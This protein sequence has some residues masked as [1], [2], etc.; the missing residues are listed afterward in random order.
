M[1]FEGALAPDGPEVLTLAYFLSNI[2]DSKDRLQECKNRVDH[3]ALFPGGLCKR[4]EN[5]K[6]W[7]VHAVGLHIRY[8]CK[9]NIYEDKSLENC[10]CFSPQDLRVTSLYLSRNCL[11][12]A[13]G[14]ER[15]V[16]LESLS[17]SDNLLSVVPPELKYLKRLR[18]LH[19]LGNP[20]C[21]VPSLCPHYR[22]QVL[23]M[24]PALEILDGKRVTP[25]EVKRAQRVFSEE[26]LLRNIVF[27]LGQLQKAMDT[28]IPLSLLKMHEDILETLG[29][30][31]ESDMTLEDYMCI[32]KSSMD[33][34]FLFDK[35]FMNVWSEIDFTRNSSVNAALAQLAAIKWTDILSRLSL[36]HDGRIEDSFE[37][38]AENM[39]ASIRSVEIAVGH[40]LEGSCDDLEGIV[41]MIFSHVYILIASLEMDFIPKDEKAAEFPEQAGGLDCLSD[42]ATNVA[43]EERAL[44][45]QE[46]NAMKACVQA[47]HDQIDE[48]DG[49]IRNLKRD[50]K[51]M[52]VVLSFVQEK[53]E[54]SKQKESQLI[55]KSD[56]DRAKLESVIKQRDEYEKKL[57]E[58][59][60]KYRTY[61]E[62]AE[63][64]L[65][66][67]EKMYSS[68]NKALQRN[69]ADMRKQPRIPLNINIV[70]PDVSNALRCKEDTLLELRATVGCLTR[71]M[72]LLELAHKFNAH[73]HHI[74]AQTAL[75]EILTGWNEYSKYRTRLK[76]LEHSISEVISRRN[77][78][79]ILS[80]LGDAVWRCKRLESLSIRWQRESQ[81]S[82]KRLFFEFWRHVNRLSS[83][84][85]GCRVAK[86]KKER[87][88]VLKILREY[89]RLNRAERNN[90]FFKCRRVCELALLRKY[91]DS[92]LHTYRADNFDRKWKEFEAGKVSQNHTLKRFFSAWHAVQIREEQS[93]QDDRFSQLGDEL[94][95]QRLRN[96]AFD[97]LLKHKVLYLKLRHSRS[98]VQTMVRQGLLRRTLSAW[99]DE[100]KS[101][102][103]ALVR[104]LF[105][106]WRTNTKILSKIREYNATLLERQNTAMRMVLGYWRTFA[107]EEARK[108]KQT[109]ELLAAEQT[110]KLMM[111]KLFIRWY[112]KTMDSQLSKHKGAIAERNL[113]V[114]LATSSCNALQTV[115]MERE[116]ENMDTLQRYYSDF[117]G[118]ERSI[119]DRCCCLDAKYR[120]AVCR[121]HDEQHIQQQLSESNNVLER[122]VSNLEEQVASLQRKNKQLQMQRDVAE[123]LQKSALTRASRAEND[124]C[125]ASNVLMERLIKETNII[126]MN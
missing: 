13:R 56:F 101:Q 89:A 78:Q 50:K 25:K 44:L 87:S 49:E 85:E 88:K 125:T 9:C 75:K 94:S 12:C 37:L 58:V 4:S 103:I 96:K 47:L 79:A 54:L 82:L 16:H 3:Q 63:A 59:Q 95:K 86:A 29:I 105:N 35:D 39:S 80:M 98:A 93:R 7:K 109:A 77:K 100:N 41:A 113:H 92:W 48:K 66:E 126:H 68:A 90:L 11:N 124:L 51:G 122:K 123:T 30:D 115:L 14:L 70:S 8:F 24:C 62:V 107:F 120:D 116:K 114:Q 45:E 83:R 110:K 111:S 72:D 67:Q 81:D 10:S 121:L 55:N 117:K 74:R 76:N 18:R 119:R 38:F 99:R 36:A 17:L 2:Y 31:K 28:G 20:M 97:A 71:E 118:I 34:Y 27:L 57:N 69:L 64:R 43:V 61:T 91:F 65:I 6:G 32:L 53:L 15:F 21:N 42:T 26:C 19:L 23:A 52:E 104:E 22:E 102:Q 40:S 73:W 60:H 84:L 33:N 1:R 108:C 112:A 46:N 106:V 5:E